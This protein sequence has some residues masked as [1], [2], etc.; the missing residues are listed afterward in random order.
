MKI[1]PI[2]INSNVNN[3][4][5]R[6]QSFKMKVD[7]ELFVK[8][9]EEEMALKKPLEQIFIKLKDEFKN[10][11]EN[12]HHSKLHG[13]YFETNANKIKFPTENKGNVAISLDKHNNL[14]YN[15]ISGRSKKKREIIYA[16]NQFKIKQ[17]V[18]PA[19]SKEIINTTRY[20]FDENSKAFVEIPNAHTSVI[21]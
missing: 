13:D 9:V 1:Q 10:L 20:T 7:R 6:N 4:K 14:I 5:S 3:R 11:Y 2:N 17:E 12:A 19:G 18:F 16:H 8:V 21:R 15:D